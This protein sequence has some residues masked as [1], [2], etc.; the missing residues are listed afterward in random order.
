MMKHAMMAAVLAG[1]SVTPTEASLP[2]GNL[3][4]HSY[5]DYAAMD[6]VLHHYDTVTCTKNEITSDAFV[7]AMNADFGSH[8]YDITFMA[9]DPIGDEWDIFRYNVIS[10][11]ITNLTQN[12]GY[13]NEDPKFSP[14][15]NKIIFKRGYWSQVLD[16]FCYDLAE[17]DLRT[18]AVAM[19]TDDAEEE[20]MPV[21]DANGGVIYSGLSEA[22][23]GIFRIDPSTGEKE[24]LFFD[25]SVTAYY[26]MTRDGRI[27]F[28]KW[29]SADNRNDCIAELT[30][31]GPVMLPFCDP[32]SNT[33]DVFPLGGDAFFYSSTKNGGYDLFYYDGTDEISLHSL[34]GAEHDLGTSF[35]SK[36]EAEETVRIA[37]DYLIHSGSTDINIDADGNGVVTG[38]DLAF[39][40]KAA[41]R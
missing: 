28:S 30:A 4:W 10:G 29:A 9:I 2:E 31:S 17:L 14:C 11:H 24:T 33:S 40:K 13:R 18:G 7:H 19:L 22:G 12:S 23:T 34:S 6:S 35:Y 5:S 26:P 21:Y 20:S 25:A 37:S 3:L 8:A 16:G 41:V 39:L 27:F 32:A 15:G 38:F 1:L 36:E